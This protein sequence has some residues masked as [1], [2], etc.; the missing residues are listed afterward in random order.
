MHSWRTPL[1][2]YVEGDVGLYLD[3]Q[4]LLVLAPA[5]FAAIAGPFECLGALRLGPDPSGFIEGANILPRGP[6]F[7]GLQAWP[8][9]C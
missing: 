8:N 1:F 3:L 4:T 2:E 7:K 5:I 9:H 6:S